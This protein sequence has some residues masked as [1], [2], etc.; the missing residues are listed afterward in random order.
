[1][2]QNRRIALNVVATYGRSLYA[3]VIGLLTGRWAL[4]ALGASDYGLY[5]VVGGLTAF[6]AFLNGLSASAVGRFYAFSVGAAKKCADGVEDCRKWFNTALLLHTVLS[7]VL[8]AVG[9]PVGAWAVRSYLAVPPDRIEVCIWV[10]RFACISC[11]V[12]MFNVPF[13][14]MYTAKQEIAELTIYSFVVT[15]L[16]FFFLLY[17]VNHPS[18]WLFEYALWMCLL[19]V[20]PQI[21][22]SVRAVYKY[23]ECRFVR[24]YLFDR[25]RIAEI[26]AFAGAR[27]LG[28]LS[29]L[30]SSQGTSILVNKMLGPTRNAAMTIGNT[31]CS[32]CS[33]LSSAFVGALSPAI[34]NS[35]GAGDKKRFLELVYLSCS[36]TCAAVL[37]F[38]I[39]LM[40]EIDEV[41]V[42]WLK[43]PPE[44]VSS[45]CF[46]LL[47]TVVLNRV[48]DGLWIGIF[49]LGKI[50]AF[51]AVES[52]L[53]FL[54]LPFSYG[55]VKAGFGI[56][57]I[58]YALVVSNL[59]AV[60]VKLYFSRKIC[61][62]SIVH[63]ICNIFMPLFSIAIMCGACGWAVR[64]CFEASVIRV[65]IVS[66]VVELVMLPLLWCFVLPREIKNRIILR[67]NNLRNL[68]SS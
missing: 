59:I 9:Y 55:F 24:A 19:V 45:L 1:M 43:N 20:V 54:V 64:E 10:W 8:V 53:W 15:T 5:G 52:I 12:G 11:F 6:V 68:F 16:N 42:I 56:A 57:G 13:Q 48:S 27:L 63:W 28:S 17:V 21:V 4:M 50:A 39:P 7:V 25:R 14:A 61:G 51:Q 47:I 18:E 66:L 38:A 67:M 46:A 23:A 58:G 3:L 26:L 29:Q 36:S 35:A 34:T 32:H 44:G 40:V 37:V 49:A 2:T 30:V 62:I 41:M 65:G 60:L 31:V 33:T 22:I